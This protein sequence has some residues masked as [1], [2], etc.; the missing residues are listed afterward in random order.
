MS[1]VKI[2]EYNGKY[3]IEQ[4]RSKDDKWYADKCIK[5]VWN[6]EKRTKEFTDQV[7]NLSIKL[8][9]KTT[10]EDTLLQLLK[11]LTGKE[12]TVWDDTFKL[13][14]EPN[15]SAPMEESPF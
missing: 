7:G 10:A 4:G 14:P 2:M 6:E 1:E 11:E 12:Y 13:E 9:D 15:N 8:G 5:P 3:R